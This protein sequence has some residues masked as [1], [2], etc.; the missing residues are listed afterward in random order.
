MLSFKSQL[1]IDEMRQGAFVDS[2]TS[3]S[4]GT[5]GGLRAIC[6]FVIMHFQVVRLFVLIPARSE[7]TGE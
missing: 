1:T 4:C 2:L 5:L 6:Y 3:K 7:K